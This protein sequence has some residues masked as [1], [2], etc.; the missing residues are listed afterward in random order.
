MTDPQI[1]LPQVYLAGPGVFRSDVAEFATVLKQLCRQHGLVPLWPMDN[2]IA[3]EADKARQADHIRRANEDMI[4][5]AD[6]VLAE[7]TPFRGP[8]MDPGTAYEIGFAVALGKPVFAW[9]PDGHTL[10]ERTVNATSVNRGGVIYDADNFAI[11]DFGLSENLMIATSVRRT[12]ATAA[13]AAAACAD[14]LKQA[15][16]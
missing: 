5:R 11:E 15:P 14:F 9:T 8:N 7:L 1:L 12:F 13:E 6:A 2:D 4:R 16:R 10:L 3:P